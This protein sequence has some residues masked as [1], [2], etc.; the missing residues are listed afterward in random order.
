LARNSLLKIS[1]GT[2]GEII[3]FDYVNNLPAKTTLSLAGC[4]IVATSAF[5]GQEVTELAV[6]R[7]PTGSASLGGALHI[8]RNVYKPAEN[9][10]NWPIDLVPLV[11]YNGK[12]V[13]SRGLAAGV[14]VIDKRSVELNLLAQ[15]RLDNLDPGGAFYDGVQPRQQSIDAG[16]ELRVR[17]GWGEVKAAWLTDTLGRHNGESAELTYRYTFDFDRWTLSP[18]VDWEW[19]NAELS[20]YYYGISAD[21]ARP[22][23]PEYAPGSSHW[24]SLGLN[25]SY[26]L[27]NRVTL[28]GNVS[29]DAIDSTITQSPIV[30]ASNTATVYVGGTFTFGN[31]LEPDYGTSPQRESEWSWRVNYGYSA[32]GNIVGSIDQ[33]NFSR[34][35]F[36][37]TNIGGITLSKLLVAG[38]RADYLARFAVYRHFESSMGNGDFNSYAVFL[39]ARGNGYGPWSNEEWFRW[40]IGFGLSFVEK[41]PIGERLQQEA[42]AKKTAPLLSYLD[43]QVDFP[44]RRLFK[45]ELV[46][47][48]Y[49]GISIVH[50]SG[51]FGSSDVLG[52]VSGGADWVT[53]HLECTR[54]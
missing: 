20:N 25:T 3:F 47:N 54:N 13:F 8:R 27:T 16:A 52:N 24:L 4:L 34:D 45:S 33:G 49:A 12:Y 21:E 7:W 36:A 50:R 17:G 14:H 41:I 32:D 1:R 11:L 40:G 26:A 2:F 19:R 9:V 31:L 18:F 51:I 53:A 5:A 38:K 22:D 29:I 10:D 28:F 39:S 15:V 23:R 42:R 37:D 43:M 46:R 48:C 44:L 6:S 35:E 30:D